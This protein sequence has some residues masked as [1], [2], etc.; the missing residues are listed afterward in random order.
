MKTFRQFLELNDYNADYLY[1]WLEKGKLSFDNIFGQDY[2]VVI[3]VVPTY[4]LNLKEKLE[5]LSDNKNKIKVD[6]KNATVEIQGTSGQGK[7]FTRTQRLGAYIQKQFGEKA[8]V[9]FDRNYKSVGENAEYF[10]ILSRHPI[11]VAKM[12]DTEGL[13]SCHAQGRE[14]FQCAMTEAQ[15]H[16]PVAF[17]VNRDSLER[18]KDLIPTKEEIFE[19]NERGIDGIDPL[20]RIR[21]RKFISNDYELAIPEVREY[22]EKIAGFYDSLKDFLLNKQKPL[23]KDEIPEMDDF[24]RDGGS[25]EDNPSSKLWNKFFDTDEFWNC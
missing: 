9:E 14:Y 6:L 22:G 11:D 23:F 3:P 20:A 13:H 2:R 4:L 1:N 10:I 18:V 17:L 15:G 8:K 25:Y 19:D 21:T 12:S 16:G 7:P 5:E 24:T